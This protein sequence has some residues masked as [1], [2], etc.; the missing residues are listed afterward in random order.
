MKQWTIDNGQFITKDK[1]TLSNLKSQMSNG[2]TL[3][4][5][6]VTTGVIVVAG[7]LLLAVLVNST[8]IYYKES[9]KIGQGLNSNDALNSIRQ[10]VKGASAIAAT[11]QV[12]ELTSLV[13][14]SSQLVLKLPSVDS[15]ENIIPDVFDYFVFLK[16]EDKLRLRSYPDIQ[17]SRLTID[18]ILSS[19]VESLLFQ[20]FDLGLPPQE[21]EAQ[22]AVKIKVTLNLKQKNGL[23]FEENISTSEASLRND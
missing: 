23:G 16:E 2:F 18:Q 4:E 13:T 6:L 19:N 10:Y 9:S 12:D 15:N 21:V 22:L 11:Y 14:N 17:S 1:K 7:V 5:L 8:G 3:V 20:Y